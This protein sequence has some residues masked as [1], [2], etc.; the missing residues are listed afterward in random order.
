MRSTVH[1]HLKQSV[2]SLAF[3]YLLCCCLNIF[4]MFKVSQEPVSVSTMFWNPSIV[5]KTTSPLQPALVEASPAQPP[6][7]T[8][9]CASF[10][11]WYM[12]YMNLYDRRSGLHAASFRVIQ[13]RSNMAE[14][15]LDGWWSVDIWF[16]EIPSSRWQWK[17]PDID[18][19]ICD[20]IFFSPG[21]KQKSLN[22]WPKAP[23]KRMTW[24]WW[25][26]IQRNKPHS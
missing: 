3:S 2:V 17:L 15:W 1:K 8:G 25:R 9:T 19:D 24:I 23:H 14:Y 21:F 20:L 4:E 10:K 11:W 12:S 7:D 18:P 26:S 5:V 16:Q 13:N 6:L 22:T